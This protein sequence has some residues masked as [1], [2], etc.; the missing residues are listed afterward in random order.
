MNERECASL[1]DFLKNVS[2]DYPITDAVSWQPA[3]RGQHDARFTLQ[4]TLERFEPNVP[5]R[6]YFRFIHNSAPELRSFSSKDWSL[7][8]LLPIFKSLDEFWK[9]HAHFE[10][11]IYLRH[12]GAPSPLLDWSQSPYVAAYFAFSEASTASHVS[13]YC[14]RDS[15][16]DYWNGEAVIKYVDPVVSKA[17][18]RHYAQQ[19]CYTVCMKDVDVD[20]CGSGVAWSSHEEADDS[21]LTKYILPYSIRREALKQ[22]QLMNIN[23]FTLYGSE[24]GLVRHLAIKH[25]ILQET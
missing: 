1:D 11:L 25:L 17:D 18:R 12:Y 19:S 22:L 7:P 5:V 6:E 16:K 20:G 9:A 24:E 2:K 4:T 23:A 13:I 8:S 21:G 15:G 3:F 10:A 14:Y